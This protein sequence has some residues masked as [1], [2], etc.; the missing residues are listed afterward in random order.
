M[1]G[2]LKAIWHGILSVPYLIL[3]GLV[4]L[5]NGF[6]AAIAALAGFLWGL[7]PDFPDAPAAPDSGVLQW[8]NWVLP[9]GPLFTGFAVFVS[10]WGVFFI[11]R[12]GLR[13]VK[14]L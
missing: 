14:M 2:F 6:L 9:L 8:I 10:L 7:L 11:V 5:L 1:I 12:W 13:W 4:A 3:D